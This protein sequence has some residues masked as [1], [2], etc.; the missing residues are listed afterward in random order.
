MEEADLEEFHG[1]DALPFPL[2]NTHIDIYPGMRG[3]HTLPPIPVG[4][5]S[6]KLIMDPAGIAPHAQALFELG[7][8][9]AAAWMEQHWAPLARDA[10][11]CA[12]AM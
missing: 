5:W 2:P 4:S 8:G 6:T 3:A 12:A 11:T 10:E 7:Q 1:V 9:D